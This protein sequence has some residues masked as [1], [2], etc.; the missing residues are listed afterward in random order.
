[1]F[2]FFVFFVLL[3][4][5]FGFLIFVCFLLAFLL[6]KRDAE[7]D[8]GTGFAQHTAGRSGGWSSG[9]LIMHPRVVLSRLKAALSCVHPFLC[10][11]Q[12][13]RCSHLLTSPP[14]PAPSS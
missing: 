2:L 9:P 5:L 11:I 4:L 12:H 13:P 7:K 6:W 3:L 14:P 1:M 10:S 8:G